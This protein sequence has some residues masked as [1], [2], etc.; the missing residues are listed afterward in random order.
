MKTELLIIE[1]GDPSVGI[2][3]STTKVT[4]EDEGL[5][6]VEIER[7][8]EIGTSIMQIL[9]CTDEATIMTQEEYEY[10]KSEENKWAESLGK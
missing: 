10:W 1:P 3:P 5:F 8:R 2:H 9:G 4:L 7:L 6:G